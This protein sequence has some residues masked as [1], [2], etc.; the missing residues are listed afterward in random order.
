ME[1]KQNGTPDAFSR[2]RGLAGD[3]NRVKEG[4]AAT[5]A[6][7]RAFLQKQRGRSPQEVLGAIAESNLGQGVFVSTMAHVILLVAFTA[8][9]YMLSS[10][11]EAKPAAK[12]EK[13]AKAEPAA[14][15]A[16]TT[17]AAATVPGATGTAQN[18]ADVMDKLGESEV[19]TADPNANPLD[20]LDK[21]LDDPD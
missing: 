5:A 3:L 10:D 13:A 14:A 6:E 9:P 11:A 16:A 18:A 8:L 19:K 7:L 2:P 17:T 20:N 4:T 15:A 21:L 1:R 12:V